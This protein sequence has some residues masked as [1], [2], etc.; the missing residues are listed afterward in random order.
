MR[1]NTAEM[2]QEFAVAE[3]AED[4]PLWPQVWSVVEQ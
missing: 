1:P 3:I 2:N 4:A